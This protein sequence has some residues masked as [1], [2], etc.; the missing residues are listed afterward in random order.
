MDAVSTD[1][2]PPPSEEQRRALE[3]L[4]AREALSIVFQPIVDLTTGQVAG[5]EALTRP[6]MGSHFAH[7][8]ELYDIAE[9][10]DRHEEVEGIARR[11]A[12]RMAHGL[13]KPP[14]LFLNNSPAVFTGPVFVEKIRSEAEA[15][16]QWPHASRQTHDR[17]SLLHRLRSEVSR[18]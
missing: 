6:E 17:L 14:L 5:Y 8:G 12:M 18:G 15:A 9:A 1:P 10:L 3:D 16:D 2:N 7:A 11:K 13:E 4:I